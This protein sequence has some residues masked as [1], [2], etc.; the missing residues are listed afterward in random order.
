MYYNT[1][2]SKLYNIPSQCQYTGYTRSVLEH[3][4]SRE[5]LNETKVDFFFGKFHY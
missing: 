5:R 1:F 3:K 4:R 2:E